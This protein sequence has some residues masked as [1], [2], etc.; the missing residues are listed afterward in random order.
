MASRSLPNPTAYGASLEGPEWPLWEGLTL[1]DL[2]CID[3]DWIMYDVDTKKKNTMTKR[4]ASW[5]Q[6]PPSPLHPLV[7]P[8][9]PLVPVKNGI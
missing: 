9:F 2:K 7:I 1:N 5:T 8:L 4:V 6:A 3:R